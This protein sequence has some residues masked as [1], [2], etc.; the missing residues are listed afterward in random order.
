ME[1]KKSLICVTQFIVRHF[2]HL[3]WLSIA[4][5]RMMNERID[6]NGEEEKKKRVITSMWYDHRIVRRFDGNEIYAHRGCLFHAARLRRERIVIVAATNQ[7]KQS[8]RNIRGRNDKETKKKKIGDIRRVGRESERKRDHP[9]RSFVLFMSAMTYSNCYF[10]LFSY[11]TYI[12]RLCFSVFLI[13][14]STFGIESILIL[15]YLFF[16]WTSTRHCDPFFF[17][18]SFSF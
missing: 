13:A 17:F 15:L 14:V 5:S 8:R 2:V 3:F 16:I 9:P 4:S 1:K 6:S 11:S 12:Y 10:Y 7:T 18:F